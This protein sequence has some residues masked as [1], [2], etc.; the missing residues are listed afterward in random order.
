MLEACHLT[1][2]QV[3]QACAVTSQCRR[4]VLGGVRSTRNQSMASCQEVNLENWDQAL[5]L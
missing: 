2:E 5:E 1:T 4:G 3:E